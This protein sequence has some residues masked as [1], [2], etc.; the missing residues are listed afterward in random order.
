MAFLFLILPEGVRMKHP[1]AHV[2]ILFLFPL[3]FASAQVKNDSIG[4]FENSVDVGNVLVAGSAVFNSNKNS[5]KISGSG[6]NMWFDKDAFH[7]V[8]KTISGDFSLSS[9]I[10]WIGTGTNPHR[11]AGIIIRQNLNA[12]SAY[13]DAVIHGDGLTSLQYRETETGTTREIQSNIK[14]PN[15]INLEKIGND[16]HLSTSENDKDF[17][18]SGCSFKINFDEPFYVGIGV[19]SH[20]KNI[21]ETAIFSNVELKTFNQIADGEEMLESSLE[22]INI[23][24]KDRKVIYHT[25]NHIEA[26]NWSLDGKYFIF[27]SNGLLYKLSAIGGTP[28][29]INTDFAIRCNNDHGLSPDNSQIVISDQSE[30]DGKSRIYTL[31]VI[32]GTPKLITKNAPSYWHGWSPDGNT[33]VYCAERNG[34]YDVYSVSINGGDE[35]RLTYAKGLDDGPE[36]SPDGK[37]IYFNSVRTGKMQIWRMNSDGNEQTQITNDEFNNWFPHPSPD[38]KWIVFLTYEKDVDGH[39]TNKDVMLRLMSLET[40]EIQILTKLF[41]GQGT[42]NVPSW[43]PDSKN[44]AFVSYRITWY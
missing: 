20:D 21:L 10:N 19:C 36:Y 40:G 41:G 44:I 24:S 4:I 5:Y 8:W 12:G 35:T 29:K 2:M 23:E 1:F 37:F 38:G 34:E 14:S 33:L 3:Y 26:P 32:G 43:S 11:K 6:E 16:V 25:K 42:I 17:Q 39:P 27:N 22:T 28:E 15:K 9:E 30:Q 7:Y 13:I 31:P 18:Y